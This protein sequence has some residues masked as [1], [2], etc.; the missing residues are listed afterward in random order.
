MPSPVRL[1]L[2]LTAL[3]AATQSAPASPDI[4]LTWQRDPTTTMTVCWQDTAP[5][6]AAIEWRLAGAD[7]WTEAAASAPRTL[8]GSERIAAHVELTGLQPDSS[9]EFRSEAWPDVLRFRTLPAALERPLVF[10]EGGDPQDGPAMEEMLRLAASRNPAFVVIGGDLTFDDGV[11]AHAGRV[12]RFFRAIGKYLVGADGRCI[13]VIACLG[14]HDVNRDRQWIVDDRALPSDAGE[15]RS[16]APYF[17]A[18]WPFPGERGYG[19]LDI[20]DY[21]A[22][23]VLD[24]NHLNA[25]DGPQ[26]NWLRETLAVRKHLPHLFPVYHVPAYPGVRDMKDELSTLIRENWTPL[27]DGAGVRLA[28]EHHEHAFKVTHPLRG[29]RM[30][31]KGAVYLGGGGMGIE[32]RDPRDPAREPHLA[33]TA[34]A[35]H[36]H[37]VVLELQRRTVHTVGPDG[38]IIYRL[39]QAVVEQPTA[40]ASGR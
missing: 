19:V 14:N 4:Y 39:E 7:R 33:K 15:R 25:V 36:L 13:P 30:H 35:H 3:L 20:G 26:L 22:F 10:V 38:G 23:V 8:P 31:E 21:L 6:T 1:L 40:A 27:F 24:T 11:P 37:E 29:G 5:G 9:Y 12:E 28:F 32:L 17:T 16:L 34:K 18:A 2:S